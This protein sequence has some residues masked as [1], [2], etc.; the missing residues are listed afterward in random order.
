[1]KTVGK[2][3]YEFPRS[4]HQF[5]YY[6]QAAFYQ[7]GLTST[8]EKLTDK[9]LSDYEMKRF[10]FIAVENK[11]TSTRPAVVYNCTDND[12]YVG[13]HGGKLKG[14]KSVPGYDQLIDDL[15]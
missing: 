14:G 11:H 8:L 2:S 10:K 7:L 5:G 13:Q 6:R 15:R 1:M 3:V 9:D 4:F 12:L